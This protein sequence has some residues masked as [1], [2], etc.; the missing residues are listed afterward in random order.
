VSRQNRGDIAPLLAIE[1]LEVTHRDVGTVAQFEAG[2]NTDMH[3]WCRHHTCQSTP[4][5]RH[6][7]RVSLSQLKTALTSS[8][9][10]RDLTLR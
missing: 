8:L 3:L 7:R 4:S 1:V 10:R 5:Q 2:G 9:P 6:V